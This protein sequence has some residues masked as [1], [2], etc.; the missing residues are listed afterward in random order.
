MEIMLDIICILLILWVRSEQNPKPR[1][2]PAK[3]VAPVPTPQPKP[4][5]IKVKQPMQMPMPMPMPTTVPENLQVDFS[6]K[7]ITELRKLGQQYKLKG[8]ARW[9]KAQAE[10]ALKELV[11]TKTK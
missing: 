1:Y 11:L 9:T 2:A 3:M 7:K 6:K 8:A 10:Q 4:I 5:T